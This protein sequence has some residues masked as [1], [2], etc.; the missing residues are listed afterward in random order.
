MRKGGADTV[1][2][3]RCGKETGGKAVF[4]PDCLMDMER[5]PVKPGTLIHIPARPVEDPRK[6]TR[7]KREL[8]TEEQLANAQHMVQALFITS[9]CLLGA[10]IVT[11]LLLVYSLSHSVEQ[12]EETEPPRGRNYTIVEPIG[13]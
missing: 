8:T 1:S 12:P 4:C 5:H 13:D 10:L 7:K 9:L 11:S 6:T 3:M 2:C